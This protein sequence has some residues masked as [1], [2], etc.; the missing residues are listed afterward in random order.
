MAHDKKILIAEDD[1]DIRLILEMVLRDAG[2]AVESIA[3]GRSI[4]ERT[5]W[6]DLLVLDKALPVVDGFAICKYLKLKKETR[7]IPIIMIS[8]Y[9][10]LKH[11]A[12]ELGVVDFIDKPF[13]LK[14]FL[15]TV[16]KHMKEVMHG[17]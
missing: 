11:K 6:P 16:D 5:E 15:A 2:Y 7:G 17:E 12:S 4:F 3:N 10:H 9:H 14:D 13:D 8:C 1:P